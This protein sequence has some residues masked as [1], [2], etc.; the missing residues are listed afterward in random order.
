MSYIHIEN[1]TISQSNDASYSLGDNIEMENGNRGVIVGFKCKITFGK[2]V[3]KVCL[4]DTETKE[5]VEI[6]R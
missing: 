5:V 6:E 4:Y 1:G 3:T 2:Q